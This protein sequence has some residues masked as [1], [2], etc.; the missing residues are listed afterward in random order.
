MK[1]TKIIYFLLFLFFSFT[2]ENF[3]QKVIK[4]NSLKSNFAKDENK[5]KYYAKLVKNVNQTFKGELTNNYS[6]W[7]KAIRNAQS[8]NL[9]DKV[10]IDGI[11]KILKLEVDKNIKLQ[12]V[13]LEVAVKTKHNFK[14]EIEKI[15]NLTIDKISY[16]IASVYLAKL[17]ND[18]EYLTLDLRKRFQKYKKDPLLNELFNY[19]SNF[20]NNIFPNSSKI[21]DLLN[22]NFQDGKTIIYSFQRKNRNYPG[23]TIIKKPNGD[24]VKNKDGSLFHIP[25]L[26]LSFSNLPGFIPNGN[27][28]Q[29]IYS[30]VGWYIS[31]TETI[32]P[33]PNI[34]VR[35]PFEVSPSIFFHSENSYSKW[36]KEDYNQLV[37]DSWKSI[38]AIYQSFNAGNS[39]RRL[40]IMHGS[41]DEIKYFEDEPFYPLTPTRGCLSA[42]EIW[43]GKTGKSIDSDQIKLINAFRSTKQ[44]KGF[45]VVVELNDLHKTISIDEIEKYFKNSPQK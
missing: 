15:F 18:L 27:T 36:K 45:L 34:L 12:K 1:K 39:G 10:V 6:D 42:K 26:A 19:L 30:I 16:S 9:E 35:S 3:S 8:I 43:S 5:E 33:T 22:H 25:Q 29:G 32:G 13:A 2:L 38:P 4:P 28:P 21:K 20:K 23:I 40:I 44:K 17:N 14:N 31:P 11:R 37:P 24:F 41:T 7:I